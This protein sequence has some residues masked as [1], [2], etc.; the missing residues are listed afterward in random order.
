LFELHVAVCL[1]VDFM[2]GLEQAPKVSID[3]SYFVDTVNE[4]AKTLDQSGLGPII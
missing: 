4:V 2:L 1:G 3:Q